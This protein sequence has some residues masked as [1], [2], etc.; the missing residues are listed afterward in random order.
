MQSQAP[1]PIYSSRTSTF[2]N[3]YLNGGGEGS[4]PVERAA[5]AAAGSAAADSAAADSAAADSVAAR[6][7]ARA[8]KRV[9]GSAAARAATKAAGEEGED[10]QHSA[11]APVG[12]PASNFLAL[13]PQNSVNNNNNTRLG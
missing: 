10:C 11:D 9:A 3:A 1:S 8:A 13:Y 4:G 6:A 12:A 2:P 5:T 7:V